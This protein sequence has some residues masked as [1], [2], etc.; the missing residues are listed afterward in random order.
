MSIGWHRFIR[1]ERAGALSD[2]LEIVARADLVG[3]Q[4]R[5]RRGFQGAVLGGIVLGLSLVSHTAGAASVQKLDARKSCR[6]AA[7]SSIAKDAKSAYQSCLNDEENARRQILREWH[8]FS[9]ASRLAC[10]GEQAAFSPSYVELQT[11]L[12]MRTGRGFTHGGGP[13]TSGA[14]GSSSP[15]GTPGFIGSTQSQGAIGSSGS[16]GSGLSTAA[17]GSSSAICPAQPTPSECPT[18]PGRVF[19]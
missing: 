10:A 18:G 4:H 7:A 5:W 16:A 12:E 6:Y 19:A 15:S 11:C 3:R 2:P 8:Q 9:T 17:I 14:P 1:A 13:S